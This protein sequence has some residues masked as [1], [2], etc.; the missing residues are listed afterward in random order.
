MN[1][2]M[3]KP[4]Q[5]G[6]LYACL[7]RQ[8][9]QQR[10]LACAG[11]GR[12]IS[13]S[14]PARS[15]SPPTVAEGDLLDEKH[16]EELMALDLLDQSFLNGIEQIRVLV[17]QLTI[18]VAARDLESTHGALHLLLGVSGNIGAKALHQFT[19][20]IYPRVVEGQWP[21]EADWLARICVLGERSA[22]ALQTYFDSAKA[23]R[24]HRDVLSDG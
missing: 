22:D 8:F 23:R 11:E 12:S 21:S 13:N 5:V 24:D 20:Q 1:E 18:S 19:R 7:A 6:S 3:I 9:A 10:G 4:V 16:L 14:R 2:V 15:A 17:A